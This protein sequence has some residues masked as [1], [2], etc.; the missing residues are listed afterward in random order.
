MK[1]ILYPYDRESYSIVV[2]HEL[3]KELEI[4]S[5]VSPKGW[6]LNGKR[7]VFADRSYVIKTDFENELLACEGVLFVKPANKIYPDDLILKKIQY[8]Y[9]QGK[10]IYYA[11]NDKREINWLKENAE[12][13]VFFN[14]NDRE[15][16]EDTLSHKFFD[17]QTPIIGVGGMGEETDKFFVQLGLRSYLGKMGYKVTQIGSRSYCGLFGF[18][19]FPQYMLDVHKEKD[20]IIFL[21]H[22][23]K[24]LE[25]QEKP[26]VILLGIPGGIMAIN[27]KWHNDFGCLM[28]EV[29]QAVSID[30][31]I[32]STYFEEYAEIF[33]KN[34]SER[35]Y[36]KYG[37]KADVFHVSNRRIDYVEGVDD[38]S[39]K[40]VSVDKEF[41]Q[42]TICK[43]KSDNILNL[44]K[45][46]DFQFLEKII[47]DDSSKG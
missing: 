36:Y 44:Q 46:D 21:N 2:F 4:K 5:L 15:K 14:T 8:A 32:M 22:Y 42:S 29:T 26:D 7:L 13:T 35:I 1:V 45:I 34:L 9:S 25:L 6:G 17:I 23:L 37:F 30:Y 47:F 28:Y 27:E 12:D 41:V 11:G 24:K 43:Y 38:S 31:F 18:H 20:K 33:Y 39:L 19:S 3:I 10:K 40:F 16:S